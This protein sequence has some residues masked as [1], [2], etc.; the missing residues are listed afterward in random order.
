MSEEI[1][2]NFKHV[3]E[4]LTDTQRQVYLIDRCLLDMMYAYEPSKELEFVLPYEGLKPPVIDAL[5]DLANVNPA[6]HWRVMS[7]ELPL[8]P[9]PTY[10]HKVYIYR[11]PSH[12]K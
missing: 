3:Y 4:S 10:L 7:E 1:T 12:E 9:N 5:L 11:M 8:W 6:Y 2:H